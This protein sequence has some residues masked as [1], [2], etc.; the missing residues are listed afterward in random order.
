[1]DGGSVH[2]LSAQIGFVIEVEDKDSRWSEWMG[3]E[4]GSSFS[5]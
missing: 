1:M 5:R 2:G 3:C 4:A